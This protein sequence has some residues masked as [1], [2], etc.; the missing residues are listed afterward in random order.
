M[1][2]MFLELP[3]GLV[4]IISFLLAVPVMFIGKSFY[5]KG[6]RNLFRFTPNMDSLVAVSTTASFF[7]G[8]FDSVGVIITLVMFG[9]YLESVSV[10]KTGDALRRLSAL[11]PDRVTVLR[12]SRET[13]VSSYDIFPGDI[14]VVKPGNRI[15][16]DGVVTEGFSHVNEALLTGESMPVE[17]NAGAKVFGGTVN[18]NGSFRYRAEKVGKDTVLAGIIA[19]V[20]KAQ[21]SKPEIARLADKVSGWFTVAV[22]T[23]ALVSAGIWFFLGKDTDFVIR[24]FVS[25]MVMACPC[26]LGLA[27]PVAVITGIGRGSELG[28]LFRNAAV[29]ETLYKIDT[30]AFDKTGTLTEGKPFVTDVLAVGMP[31]HELLAC[32]AG[33]ENRSEHPLGAA[34]VRYAA[35]KEISPYEI[36]DFTSFTGKGIKCRAGKKSLL[37][38]NRRFLEENKI[39]IKFPEEEKLYN[40]GKTLVFV[41]VNSSFAGA[42]ALS[43]RLK[44]ESG[45]A[46]DWLKSKGIKPVLLT[47]DNGRSAATV[48]EEAGIEEYYASMLPKDKASRLRKWKKE[49]LTV[50]MAGDGMNDAVAMAEA[51]V[52]IALGAGADCTKDLAHIVIAGDDIRGVC[53]AV[54]LSRQVMKTIRQN[55][56]WA[57]GYNV[58]GL[59]IAAGI[60]YPETGILLNPMIAAAAMSF[61]SLSVVTNAL[62]L[63]CYRS[64]KKN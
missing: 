25:V 32:A 12:G 62:R 42:I 41:A 46:V 35:E 17:K 37:V 9:K 20:E 16:V 3:L 50:A 8:Y 48:S 31:E 63:R 24:I 57:F 14:V 34:V 11:V 49:G 22:M 52:S 30:V 56:I 47:G 45:E 26:A 51:D 43:D 13:E 4:K 6:Y 44:P 7:Y 18:L 55:L 19:M 58:I 23:F 60:L 38:G 27:T 36:S 53:E 21:S 39:K 10:F 28:L 2:S 5:I 15:A 1:G 64:V 54:N 61:S 33:A 59:P 29:F 40:E